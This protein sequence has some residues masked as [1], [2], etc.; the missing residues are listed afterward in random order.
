MTLEATRAGVAKEASPVIQDLEATD[1]L[2]PQNWSK[3][4]KWLILIALSL[5]SLMVYVPASSI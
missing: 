1:P 3:T 4:R 5:M 2:L